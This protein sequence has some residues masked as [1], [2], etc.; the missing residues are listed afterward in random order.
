MLCMTIAT[1]SSPNSNE[2]ERKKTKNN[3]TEPQSGPQT[4]F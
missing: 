1:N 4:K 2:E 3:L